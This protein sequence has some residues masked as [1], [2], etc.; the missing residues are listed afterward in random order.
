MR[1]HSGR[2]GPGSQ[3]PGISKLLRGEGLGQP[4]ASPVKHRLG[5]AASGP[6]EQSPASGVAYVGRASNQ[7]RRCFWPERCQ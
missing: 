3:R 2:V 7:M 1:S 5:P 6:C 4:H